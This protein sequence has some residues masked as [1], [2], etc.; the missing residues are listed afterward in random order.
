M[1]QELSLV[2]ELTVAHNILLADLPVKWGGLCMDW[3]AVYERAG[4]LLETFR[5]NRWRQSEPFERG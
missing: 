4:T 5:E 3:R 2:P 1:Y